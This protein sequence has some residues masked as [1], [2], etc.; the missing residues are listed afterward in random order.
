MQKKGTPRV[1][2]NA[3]NKSPLEHVH[4]RPWTHGLY[5]IR[6]IRHLRKPARAVYWASPDP[7]P[8]LGPQE[9]QSPDPNS[10]A[11]LFAAVTVPVVY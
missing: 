8:L 9:V 2:T 10:T 6:D 11:Y 5:E 1:P 7:L 4:R 3:V